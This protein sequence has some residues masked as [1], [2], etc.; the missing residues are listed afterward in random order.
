M[1]QF[2]QPVNLQNTPLRSRKKTA[3][4]S[5][6]LA[7]RSK[8]PGSLPARR[9]LFGPGIAYSSRAR[10]MAYYVPRNVTR[11]RSAFSAESMYLLVVLAAG[12]VT[13]WWGVHSLGMDL[14]GIQTAAAVLGLNETLGDAHQVGYSQARADQQAA[15][16]TAPNCAPGQSPA[17]ANGMAAL[18]QQVGDVMGTPVECEHAASVVG[19]TVQ[20]T[21][22]GLAAYYSITN[23][24][25]FTDGW[26]HWAL[27]P[28][29]LVSWE[30]SDALPPT[31]A[32]DAA[33]TDTAA[34]GDAAPQ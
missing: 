11:K 12:I 3:R 26:R 25:T 7:V 6:H 29:G 21:S 16:V 24:V 27:T 4:P 5:P 15:A 32:G 2:V 20:Q 9:F 30:G 34:A 10:T 23:T 8:P 28:N 1:A 31:A 14:S 18:K 17:F 19:D 22:T 13:A 33:A